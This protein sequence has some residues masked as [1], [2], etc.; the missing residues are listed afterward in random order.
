MQF[1]MSVVIN[2]IEHLQSYSNMLSTKYGIAMQKKFTRCT[3]V[4]CNASRNGCK[5]F[6]RIKSEGQMLILA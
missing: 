4:H 3:Y 1:S 2:Y 5:T 6:Q